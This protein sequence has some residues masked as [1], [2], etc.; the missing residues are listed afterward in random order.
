MRITD[1]RITRKQIYTLDPAMLTGPTWKNT[2]LKQAAEAGEAVHG[3]L[4]VSRFRVEFLSHILIEASL[5]LGRVAAGAIAEKYL[6]LAH[7][8][9]IVAFVS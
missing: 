8:I 2:A 5:H 6:K 9:E 3:K 4:L 1:Q 7:G